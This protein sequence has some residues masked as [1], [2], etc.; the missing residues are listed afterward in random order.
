[1]RSSWFCVTCEVENGNTTSKINRVVCAPTA[2]LAKHRAKVEFG[3]N[4]VKILS[5]R[6]LPGSKIFAE[7]SL[8]E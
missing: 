7:G 4:A 6:I 2:F 3:P 1:M 5:V 8:E